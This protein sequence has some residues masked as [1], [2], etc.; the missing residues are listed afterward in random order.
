MKQV[1]FQTSGTCSKCINFEL[2]EDRRLHNVQFI[3]GCPGNTQGL[4]HLVEGMK[5]EDVITRLKNIKCGA[6]PTSCPDQLAQALENE[7]Q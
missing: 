3:G 4:S 6:K 1:T 2:D 5:A 7:I